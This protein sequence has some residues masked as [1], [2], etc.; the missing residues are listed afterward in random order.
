MSPWLKQQVKEATDALKK[1]VVKVRSRTFLESAIA[2]FTLAAHAGGAVKPEAKARMTHFIRTSGAL[3]AFD[4]QEVDRCFEKHAR[5]YAFDPVAAEAAALDEI[6]KLKGR[7]SEARLLARVC[8]AVAG[9]D[10][11][12]GDQEKRALQAIC[13][14]LGLDPREFELEEGPTAPKPT[15]P[16]GAVPPSPAKVLERGGRVSLA[17]AAPNLQK[18]RVGLGWDAPAGEF[19]VDASAFLLATGD[20]VR[21]DADFIFYNQPRSSCGAVEHRGGDAHDRQ[22]LAID[23]AKVPEAVRKI[24][25]TVTI[26]EAEARG[27]RFGQVRNA[28]VRVADADGGT[29]VIRYSLGADGGDETAM[30]F[31]ELYRHGGGWRFAAVGQGYVGGLEAMC[32]RFGVEV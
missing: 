20:K 28:Y 5:Q 6:G 31:G 8:I 13:T 30:I 3:S 1:T 23:L 19:D 2:A 17:Q 10:G 32:R 21:S 9:A 12:F 7:E 24:V 18:I 11:V 4:P 22:V 14:V 26:H 15:P 27:Q 29:E 16:P 25:F